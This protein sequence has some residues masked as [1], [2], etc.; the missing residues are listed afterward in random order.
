M[1]LYPRFDDGITARARLRLLEG[2]TVKAIDDLTVSIGITPTSINPYLLRAEI[3]A[4]RK[5]WAEAAAD[6][7]EAIRLQPQEADYYLNR[8][9][10]RYN[11]D[12]FFGAMADYNYALEL[13]PYNAA[14][15]FNRALLRYEVRDLER[16][17]KD[18]DE[19]LKIEPDNFHAQYNRSLMMLEAGKYREALKGF[20]QIAKRYPRFYPVYYAMAEA[21]QKLGDMRTAMMNVYKAEELIKKYV[22][23]PRQFKLDRPSIASGSTNNGMEE[24]PDSAQDE[25]NDMKVM[26]KFNQL[27]TVS[28]T[29]STQL[30]YNERIKGKVQDRD[31]SIVAQPSYM[32]SFRESPRS[33][34][35]TSN[36]FRDLDLFNGNR[37]IKE[38]IYL[39]PAENS[40]EEQ[41]MSSLFSISEYYTGLVNEGRARPADWF[42]SGVVYCMLK[43]Y[44]A[45]LQALDKAIEI[46]PGFTVAYMARGFIHQANSR[47]VATDGELAGEENRQV[48]RIKEK[49]NLQEAMADYDK[50]LELDPRLVYAWFNK[51]NLYYQMKD[52]SSAMQCYSEALKIDP[53][54]GEAYFNRGLTYFQMGNRRQAFVDLS[55]A[56]E[57]GVIQSYNLLKR[58]K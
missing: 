36:Y 4:G 48:R 37:Y 32:L 19:V 49:K 43:N 44:E 47:F 8:A 54:F 16:A 22:K 15:L 33:L 18:L 5:Q 25:D 26:E 21:W 38:K 41:D 7:D 56:G 53:E 40:S 14:A 31:M 34:K 10:L 9:Y 57:T 28:G 39:N 35:T 42:A 2:D 30:S 55:K 50:A 12:E 51:G 52:Y 29:S 6:M 13:K 45:A 17:I 23:N 20:D 46:D 3:L 24:N 1:R 58:M 27:V 11:N